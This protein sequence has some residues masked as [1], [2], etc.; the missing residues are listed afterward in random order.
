MARRPTKSGIQRQPNDRDSALISVARSFEA[1][2]KY[3]RN[4]AQDTFKWIIYTGLLGIVLAILVPP[5]TTLVD[6]TVRQE[7]TTEDQLKLRERIA[8][9]RTQLV[10]AYENYVVPSNAVKE[11]LNQDKAFFVRSPLLEQEELNNFMVADSWTD[12]D[13]SQYIIVRVEASNLENIEKRQPRY[14]A[15][16]SSVDGA[17]FK[18][19]RELKFEKNQS[20]QDIKIT[21]QGVFVLFETENRETKNETDAQSGVDLKFIPHDNGTE[22]VDSELSADFNWSARSRGSILQAWRSGVLLLGE[23]RRPIVTDQNR[24]LSV[25]FFD[26]KKGRSESIMEV[27]VAKLG[28]DFEPLIFGDFLILKQG[29]R[30]FDDD[31]DAPDFWLVDLKTKSVDQIQ[32]PFRKEHSESFVDDVSVDNTSINVLF[33]KRYKVGSSSTS[34]T[35]AAAEFHPE[36]KSFDKASEF[37]LPDAL[38]LLKV[39]KFVRSSS[40]SF[41]LLGSVQVG[42][43]GVPRPIMCESLKETTNCEEFR[44]N[45]SGLNGG[46][47]ELSNAGAIFLDSIGNNPKLIKRSILV[48]GGYYDGFLFSKRNWTTQLIR[49]GSGEQFGKRIANLSTITND[50]VAPSPQETKL[51]VDHFSTAIRNAKEIEDLRTKKIVL[52]SVRLSDKFGQSIPVYRNLLAVEHL[53]EALPILENADETAKQKVEKDNDSKAGANTG[54]Q[55]QQLVTRIAVLVIFAYLLHLLVVR[56]RIQQVLEEHNEARFHALELFIGQPNKPTDIVAST[57]V[58][59]ELVSFSDASLRIPPNPP[60]PPIS[61]IAGAIKNML[62]KGN[63]K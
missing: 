40:D 52:A 23:T 27:Q 11:V 24:K 37:G 62:E 58:L 4:A 31:P 49:L 8:Q 14:L 30:F 56:Q 36:T 15:L 53:P 3:H 17:S 34:H 20:V 6:R 41:T 57:K 32:A 7:T 50:S 33:S 43:D 29:R 10:E 12:T 38:D 2:S 54:T 1:R 51:V 61:K 25:I 45:L 18:K 16:H 44:Y 63:G 60:A 55:L 9:V 35:V 46:S 13:N 48:Q 47:P 5:L 42:L 22:E 28:L 26:P 21:K 39:R 59:Q 19:I